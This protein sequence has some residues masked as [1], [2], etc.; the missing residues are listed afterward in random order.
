MAE[1]EGKRAM[2]SLDMKEG[3]GAT[4][5]ASNPKMKLIRSCIVEFTG[6]LIFIFI[7]A[8]SAT[9]GYGAL[10]AALAHGITIFVLIAA[11]GHI[12]GGHYNPAV[13]LGILISGNIPIIN[14]V[15]YIASQLSGGL[16]GAL[17]VRAVTHPNHRATGID[18]ISIVNGGATIPNQATYPME[19]I[20]CE[21]IFTYLLVLTVLLTAVDT[22]SNTLAPLAIGF[23][24]AADILAGGNISGASM[25]PARSFGPAV[26]LSIFGNGHAHW[27]LY[28]IYWVGQILGAALAGV[29]YKVFLAND[30]KRMLLK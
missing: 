15:C 20:T 28:Y 30:E 8:L 14:A 24:I 18:Y 11:M 7:G 13:T 3:G 27:S 19:A 29:M 16:V 9:A 5:R 4:N 12:S 23:S 17:L 10:S 21:I 6:D 22:S 25:N 1:K 26:V 2:E